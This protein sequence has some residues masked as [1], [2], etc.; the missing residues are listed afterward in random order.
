MRKSE[1][2][3]DF[4]SFIPV[5]LILALF[6]SSCS[7]LHKLRKDPEVTKWEQEV[8]GL[9]RLPVSTNPETVLF[10]G[11]SSIRLWTDVGT[12]MLPYHAIARGYGG[13]KLS[14]FV[15]YCRR[16]IDP[17]HCGAIVLFIAND[18]C[19]D[20][21]DRTPQQVLAL[22]KLTV[23]ELRK[24][25]PHTPIFWIAI[26]PTPSRWQYWPKTNEANRLIKAQCE[27]S[28]NLFFIPTSACFLGDDGMPIPTLFREDMLHLNARGYSI[29]STC[30]KNVLDAHIAQMKH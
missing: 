29:W 30:I 27:K 24:K 10:A 3:H 1:A 9:E 25:H 8:Q 6:V 18:I 15:C 16:I 17:Q 23:R 14:D 26:T 19:G 7:P 2:Q 20:A 12:D 5:I 22:M 21:N 11:S 28:E 13:A 4:R